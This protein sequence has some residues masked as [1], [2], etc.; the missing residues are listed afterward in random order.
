[1]PSFEYYEKGGVKYDRITRVLDYFAPPDLVKWKLKVGTKEAKR[2]GTIAMKIGSHIDE[3]IRSS[4]GG[5]VVKLKGADERN[6]FEAWRRW[7]DEYRASGLESAETVFDDELMMAG[8]PDLLWPSKK[9]VIDLKCS[10][11]IRPQYWLQ[12]EFYG[13]L[14]GYERKAVLRLDKDL[15][16]YEY[17]ERALDDGV[18]EAV[19]G[20]ISLYRYYQESLNEGKAEDKDDG[21]DVTDGK[22]VGEKGVDESEVSDD[23]AGR[24]GE[25]RV[26]ES[27]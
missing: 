9:L 12:T 26:L 3:A 24:G 27:W 15:G 22:G 18:W 19:K 17:E 13:R 5:V 23:R 4:L 11:E 10:R 20:A 2:I 14:L 7:V 25:E 16:V 1:M 21:D 6:C 8:T